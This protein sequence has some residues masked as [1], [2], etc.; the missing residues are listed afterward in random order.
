M[1]Q[2][3]IKKNIL[4]LFKTLSLTFLL[5]TFPSILFSIFNINL[6]K[7]SN[8]NKIIL[9]L[10]SDIVFILILFFAYRKKILNDFKNFFN[11]N[12]ST[13][14]ETA[15]K[16]WLIG[17]IIMIVS[18]LIIITFTKA[19]L[20][21]NEEA[22]RTLIDNYPL[23][24][25]FSTVI[26]APLTEE[27]IFRHGFREIIKLKYLYIIISGFVFGALHVISSAD[28]PLSLLHLIPY[29]SLGFAFASLYT[30][31]NNIFSTISMHML[32]NTLAVTVY[33]IGSVL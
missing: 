1:K 18:N 9:L 23:Y 31:T 16:Y 15:F 24:M 33:L 21:S 26:Y 2:K 13:N 22:V 4:T 30:K 29:C 14:I 27:L 19:G 8:S 3:D 10:T 17:F 20:A 6:D 5:L 25:I 28:T 11:K 12:F 32:H 7:I